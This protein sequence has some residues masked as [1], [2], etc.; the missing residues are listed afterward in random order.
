LIPVDTTAVEPT[1]RLTAAQAT[2]EG[3]QDQEAQ[4]LVESRPAWKSIAPRLAKAQR[5]KC[6]YCEDQL[7]ERV[8]E[9]DHVRPKK[10]YW[11]LAYRR[12]NLLAACRS[13]NNAKSNK[14]ELAGGSALVP[15]DEPWTTPESALFIDPTV[16]LPYSHITYLKLDGTWRVAALTGRGRW[17]INALELDR[18]SRIKELNQM[19]DELIEPELD[20]LEQA[21]NNSNRPEFD[22]SR[23]RLEA[24]ANPEHRY[25][26]FVRVVI[27]R[28][29]TG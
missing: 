11:W 16:D 27:E 17:T 23:R 6:A 14:W 26:H 8:T 5:E 18:D 20:R 19:A 12:R 21:A 2:M 3:L 1:S 28:R 22:E 7:R 13:C 10:P 4:A 9:V 29:L 24:L 25:S 15:R